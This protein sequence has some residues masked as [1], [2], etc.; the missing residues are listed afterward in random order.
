MSILCKTNKNN[1]T[2]EEYK[3]KLE[4]YKAKL[5]GYKAKLQEY[6]NLQLYVDELNTL[7][8]YIG[9]FSNYINSY[10]TQQDYNSFNP[11]SSLDNQ[12][13]NISFSSNI[14]IID[15][16]IDKLENI[17]KQQ[18]ELEKQQQ[19]EQEQQQPP[20]PPPKAEKQQ[21]KE[22]L[23]KLKIQR[24]K[25][26]N[27]HNSDLKSLSEEH[28]KKTDSVKERFDQSELKRLRQELTTEEQKKLENDIQ[29]QI[30][31]TKQEELARQQ[32]PLPQ[33]QPQPPQPPLPQPPN[34]QHRSV[35]LFIVRINIKP[36]QDLL[37]ETISLLTNQKFMTTYT[38]DLKHPI[39]AENE[40]YKGTPPKET[41]RVTKPKAGKY[42]LYNESNQQ[43]YHIPEPPDQLPIAAQ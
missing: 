19:A 37:Q 42:Y 39:K 36:K 10:N 43:Y 2:I 20:S 12:K 26:A 33:P 40:Q 17:K 21:K 32:P 3:A 22:F 18:E 23:E 38:A 28:Q 27:K 35:S 4:G 8:E 25:N 6:K 14:I 30:N 7:E 5:E 15:I 11:C 1:S 13:L 16:A 29:Q 24:D 41:D 31:I 34:T 9:N